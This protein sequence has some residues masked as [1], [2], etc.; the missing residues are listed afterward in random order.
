MNGGSKRPEGRSS[1]S[2]TATRRPVIIVALGNAP[3]AWMGTQLQL[4]VVVSLRAFCQGL[5]WKRVGGGN[6]LFTAAIVSPASSPCI[7]LILMTVSEEASRVRNLRPSQHNFSHFL[8]AHTDCALSSLRHPPPSVRQTDPSSFEPTAL[9]FSPLTAG[10]KASAGL[11]HLEDSFWRLTQP[12]SQMSVALLIMMSCR[13][14]N[15]IQGER[16]KLF[17]RRPGISLGSSAFFGRCSGRT[18]IG[19]AGD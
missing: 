12:L 17:V 4:S 8:P 2:V 18:L 7:G 6:G 11:Q 15:P 9:Y 16:G 19:L 13:Q 3:H 10:R 5:E 1:I 14:V